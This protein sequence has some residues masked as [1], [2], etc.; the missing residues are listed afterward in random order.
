MKHRMEN[1]NQISNFKVGKSFSYKLYI[2][3]VTLVSY[4]KAKN[5]VLVYPSENS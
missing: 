4:D 3:L 2:G 5:V 1:G